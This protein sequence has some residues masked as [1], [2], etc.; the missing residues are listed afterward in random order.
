MTFEQI[1]KYMLIH[2]NCDIKV[3]HLQN[4]T[5]QKIVLDYLPFH[6]FEA[7]VMNSIYFVVGYVVF[8]PCQVIPG[9]LTNC[10]LGWTSLAW[11]GNGSPQLQTLICEFSIFCLISAGVLVTLKRCN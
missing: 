10:L 11:L 5:L 7:G 2:S 8:F 6:H 9:F 1:K 4:I 3:E